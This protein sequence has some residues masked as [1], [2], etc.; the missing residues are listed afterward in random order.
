[1]G[2]VSFG[3]MKIEI[4][5]K[6]YGSIEEAGTYLP[7]DFSEFIKEWFDEKP[8]ILAHTSGSTGKPKEIRLLKADMKA[9]ARLTNNFFKIDPGSRLLLCLSPSYI[10]GKM[11]IVRWLLS[12]GEIVIRKPSINPLRPNDKYF[13]F[14]AMVPAQVKAVMSDGKTAPLIN[15]IGSLIVGGAPLDEATEKRLAATSTSAYAT[16]GMTETMSH[17]ALRKIGSDDSYFALGSVS[18]KVDERGCLAIKLPHLSIGHIVTN[19]MVKLNDDRHFKW[20]GRYDN[21]I[22]SGGIKIMPEEIEKILRP[23]IRNRFYITGVPDEKWGERP[24]VVIEGEPWEI[25]EQE[26]LHALIDAGIESVKRP[27]EI[28]FVAQ[29]KE[30]GSGKIL[31]ESPANG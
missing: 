1:M 28:I 17:V 12:G 24:V 4:E 23:H 5:G 18:F 31:R 6:K 27:K 21:V 26:N 29:F 8:Y 14:A 22:N 7:E 11:M 25:E 13:H 19:D 15:N 2:F 16:Y 3:N 9:S 20:L 30:T 10:A